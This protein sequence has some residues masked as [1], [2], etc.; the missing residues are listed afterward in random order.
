MSMTAPVSGPPV[1]RRWI[2]L[3]FIALAQLM[4]VLDATVVNIALPSAQKALEISDANRQWMITAYTLAFGG[5]LLFGG[6]VGDLLGRKRAFLIGLVGFAGASALG[7]AAVNEGMLLGARALQGAFGALLAPSALSLLAVTFTA[8]KERA[9]AFGI[10]GAIAGGGAAI[11]LI[12]GGLLTEYLNWRWALYVNVPVAAI[13]LTG[14]LVFVRD[15]VIARVRG[16]L[17]LPGVVLVTTGL[18][19]LVYG[20]TRAESEG[21]G[22]RGVVGLFA[23]AGVLLVAFV[24]VERLTRAPL[25]PLRV[26]LDRNR[27][28]AY[29]AV[30]LSV[31][32]MFGLFLFM[33]YYLQTVKHYSPVKTG[34]AFLPLTAGMIAGSTQISARLMNH[35]PARLLMV[36]GLL[37]AAAGIAL[38]TR[39]QVDSAYAALVLPSQLLL[40]VGLGTALMPAMNL[41][42]AGV[43]AHDAGVA[44][45]MVNTSQQVGGSL[46][47]ALLNTIGATATTSYIA[48]HAQGRPS[49][50]LAAAGLVHGFT[51]ALWWAMGVIC[52]AAAAVAVLINSRSERRVARVAAEPGVREAVVA[53]EAPQ[54]REFASVGARAEPPRDDGTYARPAYAA[55]ASAAFG[56]I[57]ARVHGRVRG[58]EGVPVSGAALTLIDLGGR[59]VDRAGTRADGSYMLTAPGAGPYMLIAAADGHQPQAATVVVGDEPLSYDVTLSGTAGLAGIVRSA[60]TGARVMGAMVVVTDAHGEVIASAKTG[61]DG[62]FSFEDLVSGTFVVAVSAG[63]HRPGALPVD[64][65]GQ[66]T[67][68]CEVELPAGARMHGTVRAGTDNLLLADAR[69]TLVDAAGNVV[70]TATTG[71]EGEYAFEDLDP[72]P[73][74]VIASGY[75]PVAATLTVGRTSPEAFGLTLSHPDE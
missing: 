50:G 10:Y 48:T 35:V 4:V 63:G 62:E 13:G 53:A 34:L 1:P 55:S 41:A 71:A 40:G 2:A 51:V 70:A 16:R 25:L 5:L 75:P 9:K 39:L 38:L 21:W 23:A 24:V 56:D 60:T 37:V 29:L 44:S 49:P 68:H 15:P 72:G 58:G 46:G 61:P 64:V 69:V 52:L 59:Q 45:A 8:P 54:I 74:T 20:F 17:D 27:G 19:A 3:V 42:T 14:G 11:G 36:P 73:Y 28:G 22:E 32:G 43:A 12:V 66:G 30:G 26:I 67:T 18:I 57:G 7:G 31:I 6:R 65:A 47:T 33:T